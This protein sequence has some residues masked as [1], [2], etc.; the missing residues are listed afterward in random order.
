[1]PHFPYIRGAAS[2]AIDET[3]SGNP[4]NLCNTVMLHW[5]RYAFQGWRG[6]VRYK[7]IP[8][9]FTATLNNLMVQRATL[10][11]SAPSYILQKSEMP[12][13]TSQEALRTSALISKGITGIPS[14]ESPCTGPN[15]MI[16]AKGDINQV[17]EFEMPFYSKYRFEPGKS[18]LSPGFCKFSGAWD[19]VFD[20]L[21][22]MDSQALDI[23]TSAGEDFQVYFYVGLPRMYYE[24]SPPL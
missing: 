13:F 15:G 23:Y 4:Y 3:P 12:S 5:V 20:D 14:D 24:P 1:M 17:L 11:E 22:T 19:Y 7:I 8:R 18:S 21:T 6:S 9:G 2:G 10:N 16:V